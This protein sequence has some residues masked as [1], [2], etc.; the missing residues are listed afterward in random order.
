MYRPE[1]HLTVADGNDR[2]V[3]ESIYWADGSSGVGLFEPVE[4]LAEHRR[5]GF[6][7]ALLA[8]GLRRM[9]RSGLN[10]A[11]VSHYNDNVAGAALYRSV[12][13]QRTFE[14]IVYVPVR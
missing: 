1:N 14:R 8:E 13:F 7:R 5:R 10:V 9:A 12:G 11:K 3:A 2:A 4:T 6:G